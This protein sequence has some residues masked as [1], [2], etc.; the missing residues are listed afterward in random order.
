MG[1]R[2]VVAEDEPI[3][4]M[5]ICEM[6]KTAGYSVVGE[7]A[8][9]LQAVE[10]CRIH[11]PELVLMDIKMP[12]LDGI[13]ASEILMKEDIAQSIIVLTAYSGK[14]FIDKVKTIG[15]IGYIVKPID[16]VRLIPQVEIA[17][18]KG[19]ELKAM[20]N[21]LTSIKTICSAKELLMEKFR[22]SENEAYKKLRRMS[23]D[24]QTTIFQVS[25]NILEHNE[26]LDI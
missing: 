3:T 24:K 19:Q 1:S 6:L 26:S 17:I 12:K 9:G 22:L 2:I 11:R 18:S 7:A 10:L 8:N 14:E 5:D 4:R 20:R 25:Q 23:M 13:Q 21:K 15:A 16:E